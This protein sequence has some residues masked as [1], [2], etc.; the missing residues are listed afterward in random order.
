MYRLI[1]VFLG[2]WIL[3]APTPAGAMSC[4]NDVEDHAKL[5]GI[6]RD[7]SSFV[8]RASRGNLAGK[9]YG[10]VLY[11]CQV[12]GTCERFVISEP[13]DGSRRSRTPKSERKT[14]LEKAK[15]A[16]SAA[17]VERSEH[18]E[19]FTH[20][21]NRP[22]RL[23][24]SIGN[25]RLDD[26]AALDFDHEQNLLLT[27]SSGRAVTLQPAQVDLGESGP[28]PIAGWALPVKGHEFLVHGGYKDKLCR[29]DLLIAST[30]LDT[31]LAMEKNQRGVTAFQEGKLTLA[32]AQFANATR[33]NPGYRPAWVNQAY[34]YLMDGK[35][36]EASEALKKA[37]ALERPHADRRPWTLCG[38]PKIPEP[39]ELMDDGYAACPETFPDDEFH[40]IGSS[41]DG[42]F[43]AVRRVI[44]DVYDE[45][46]FKR[47]PPIL[48]KPNF[49]TQ[50][51]L[52]EVG[53]DCTTPM[54]ISSPSGIPKARGKAALRKAKQ[55]F[56]ENGVVLGS[57]VSVFKPI[58][59]ALDGF[60]SDVGIDG[61]PKINSIN[62]GKAL[63]VQAP[64][65]AKVVLAEFYG[66]ITPLRLE[67]RQLL[68]VHRDPCDGFAG[69]R[70]LNPN[71]IAARIHHARGITAFNQAK[72]AEASESLEQAARLWPAW[73][74][75]KFDLAL[76][77]LRTNDLKGAAAAM[78]DL[79][80]KAKLKRIAR[81][82]ADVCR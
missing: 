12:G 45:E 40:H 35:S 47:G 63:E 51:F 4:E 22:L 73:R 25:T 81:P 61:Q 54:V 82:I 10:V 6:S 24:T 29:R 26:D 31:L 9:N 55:R 56:A 64:G 70:V 57:Q 52:C 21:S 13:T 20:E 7:G 68:L 65:F 46:S 19:A 37:L 33:L 48:G 71:H 42:Q 69:L 11:L 2:I 18:Q 15:T 28:Y 23:S 67:S 17:Q 39:H 62:A 49:G 58:D 44:R 74:Q 3:W 41:S 30:R 78:E 59:G 38:W 14:N 76:G 80:G 50:L 36:K 16:I 77:R 32:A 79:R 72:Y 43:V 5:I 60:L 53:E 8:V 27:L 1:V 75:A 34:T 66:P